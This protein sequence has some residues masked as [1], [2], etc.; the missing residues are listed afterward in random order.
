MNTVRALI[1]EFLGSDTDRF[2]SVAD[3]TFNVK[4]A[5]FSWDSSDEPEEEAGTT[6]TPT[7]VTV[8]TPGGEVST[9]SGLTTDMIS[10]FVR[11]SAYRGTEADP[12]FETEKRAIK[13]VTFDSHV[14][15]TVPVNRFLE[16]LRGR[17][18][19]EIPIIVASAFR[20]TSR[21]ASAMLGVWRAGGDKQIGVVYSDIVE[22]AFM[23]VINKFR[24]FYSDDQLR[25]RPPPPLLLPALEAVI[26][27]LRATGSAFH[28]G[29]MV[30][31]G[32]DLRISGM[33]A[34]D[35]DVILNA[36]KDLGAKAMI[37]AHPYHLHITI[38]NEW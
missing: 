31:R 22:S 11:D 38:P 8:S 1:R 21:Q 7:Q 19:P 23:K 24:E 32:I 17:V 37:E 13:G 26:S 14:T 2:R 36:A 15:S 28:T 25:Q 20:D 5:E 16:A 30:G 34:A 9:P 4:P 27:S 12:D 33:S 10:T 29:H 3:V 18:P 35:A 6:M